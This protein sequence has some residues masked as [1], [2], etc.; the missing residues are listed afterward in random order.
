MT[1]DFDITNPTIIEIDAGAVFLEL[2][3]SGIKIGEASV[4][5]FSLKPGL[6]YF[7]DVQGRYIPPVGD[8]EAAIARRFLSN[9]VRGASQKIEVRGNPDGTS[10]SIA[11]LGPA[12]STFALT[13]Y[14][15]GFKGRMIQRASFKI[16][17]LPQ[18]DKKINHLQV[19]ASAVVK[20]PF[21]AV[22]MLDSVHCDVYAC[23]NYEGNSCKGYDRDRLGVYSKSLDFPLNPQGNSRIPLQTFTAV[24]WVRW[25]TIEAI[26]RSGSGT[27]QARVQCP[28]VVF[29]VDAF[30][31]EVDFS[32]RGIPLKM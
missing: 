29:S 10:S 23:N 5:D 15:P 28:Q 30:S 7:T 2:W 13:S 25:S 27:A 22:L 18:S 26:F 19:S 8:R 16:K 11:L 24:N 1:V 17:P 21:S 9:Y 20:N 3:Y 6:N 4:A 14:V 32:Q 12:L 31:A